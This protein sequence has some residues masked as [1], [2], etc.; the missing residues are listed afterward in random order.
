MFMDQDETAKG[1]VKCPI[2]AHLEFEAAARF[3][4]WNPAEQAAN[5]ILSLAVGGQAAGVLTYCQ[6]SK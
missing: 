3:S 1:K 2:A 4:G 5:L 6:Q